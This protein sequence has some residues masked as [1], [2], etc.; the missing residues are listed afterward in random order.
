MTVGSGCLCSVPSP[1]WPLLSIAPRPAS[2]SAAFGGTR[3]APSLEPVGS[4]THGLAGQPESYLSRSGSGR[5]SFPH[6]PHAGKGAEAPTL[7]RGHPS[8]AAPKALQAW[9]APRGQRGPRLPP[10]LG[11]SVVR[12]APTLFLP[13]THSVQV[14]RLSMGF[15]ASCVVT[16]LQSRHCGMRSRCCRRLL[17][18]RVDK[19]QLEVWAGRVPKGVRLSLCHIQGHLLHCVGEAGL[20]LG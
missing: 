3:P 9:W 5:R 14:S 13:S 2:G 12:L 11:Q 19:G 10:P 1:A 16:S 20:W 6:P 17:G 4:W 15:T 8:T 18:T 7:Q